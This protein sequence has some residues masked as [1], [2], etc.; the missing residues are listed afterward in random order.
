MAIEQNKLKDSIYSDLAKSGIEVVQL[1]LVNEPYKSPC[2]WAL[3]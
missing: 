2:I 3:K 1:L